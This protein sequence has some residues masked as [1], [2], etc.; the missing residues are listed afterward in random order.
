MEFIMY[1]EYLQDFYNQYKKEFESGNRKVNKNKDYY[2]I[3]ISKIPSML[4]SKIKDTKYKIYGSAGQGHLSQT[5]WFGI[6]NRH[7]TDTAT[8][9]LYIVYLYSIENRKLFLTLNQGFTHY[10]EI[11]KKQK[12][13]YI[14]KTS[15]YFANEMNLTGFKSDIPNLGK[16]LTNLTKGYAYGAIVYKEY[17]IDNLP[18]DDVLFSDLKILI[19]EYDELVTSFGTKSYDEIIKIVNG[20]DESI[21]VSR[22]ILKLKTELDN[23]FKSPVDIILTPKQVTKGKLKS[24]KYSRIKNSILRQKLDYVRIAKDNARI[25]LQGEKIALQIEKD[26]LEQ[27]GITNIDKKCV[28]R[29][30]ES[31]SYG[32]DIESVDI[33]D[34]VETTIYIEVKT[35]SDRID[36]PF[37][38]SKRE[39]EFSEEKK[40]LYRIIRIFDV[41]STQP[42]FYYAEG[43]VGDNFILDPITYL[44][45][46]KYELE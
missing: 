10:L 42:K 45:T 26:R 35:T 39:K 21:S 15:E 18:S 24:T 46:Y 29:A 1:R 34:G 6:F 27:L 17:D 14:R 31:D 37:Y 22:A 16:S 7:L 19:K 9:G 25:G 43:Q 12:F 40:H 3:L 30:N 41:D 28:W 13:E 8:Y 32:Y 4:G 44:A 5:P 36:S 11:Y 23:N 38:I 33:I 20:T 2:T